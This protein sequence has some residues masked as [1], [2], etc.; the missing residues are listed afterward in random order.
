MLDECYYTPNIIKGT[1]VSKESA[2]SALG[3]FASIVNAPERRKVASSE[4][5]LGEWCTISSFT[6][7]H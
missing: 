4:F 3:F 1:A 7:V 2:A 5:A 6:V